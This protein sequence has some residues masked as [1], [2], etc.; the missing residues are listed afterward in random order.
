MSSTLR[1]AVRKW[2]LQIVNQRMK[3]TRSFGMQRVS[4]GMDDSVIDPPPAHTIDTIAPP[5]YW[6]QPTPDDPDPMAYNRKPVSSAQM[7]DT[8]NQCVSDTESVTLKPDGKVT[9]GSF[10]ELDLSQ[11]PGVPLEYL[12]LLGPSAE[13]AAA[14]RTLSTSDQKGTLLVYGAS[15][16]A[17]LSAVQLGSAK[18]H[19]VVAVVG[20]EHSGDVELCDI[21]KNLTKDPGFMIP[22]EMAMV[23]QSYKDLVNGILSPKSTPLESDTYLTDFQQNLLDYIATYPETL[24]AAV[25]K[26][27][28]IF[29]GKD[30]DRVYY[31]E[32]MEAYLEQFTRGA[33]SIPAQ[34]LSAKFTK[35][36][37]ELWKQKFGKQTTSVI[38]GES[39]P[40][41]EPFHL[42]KQMVAQPE[43]Y[44][45][46]SGEI[47]Y[48]FSI[49]KKQEEVVGA[50]G[51]I[52]GAVVAV[53]PYLKNACEA[54]EKAKTLR[55]KA[56][57][58]QFLPMAERNAYAA[59]ASVVNM[60]KAH[61]MPTVVVG[62]SLPGFTSVET[63]PEDVSTALTSMDMKEDGSSDL[64]HFVQVYRA[65]DFPIYADYAVHRATEVLAGPRQIVVTK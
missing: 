42:A 5:D 20:G 22:E 60:A 21:V 2:N 23:K 13:G 6:S 24:P 57:A 12:A 47:P 1:F 58:L 65:G 45:D 49:L 31:R 26:D 10:G 41:F 50:A 35:E 33:P 51:P 61:G 4:N 17:A 34:E 36:Q 64:N 39:T 32:N 37:Y 8:V 19:A 44:E 7:I 53:T 11:H 18:G 48:E 25:D 59:A 63:T 27:E 62:G 30:K 54:V 43:T 14:L 40:D 28:L 38:S 56:E 55:E 29:E 46:Q 9:H 3:L 15:Q 52:M 16:P